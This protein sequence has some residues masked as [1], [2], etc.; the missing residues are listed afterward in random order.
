V[1]Y[2]SVVKSLNPLP[3]ETIYVFMD[4]TYLYMKL[5]CNYMS[6]IEKHILTLPSINQCFCLFSLRM[7]TWS[8]T[9]PNEDELLNAHH[10]ISE[11][12]ITFRYTTTL[13]SDGIMSTYI[14]RK[15]TDKYQH[16]FH[17]WSCPHI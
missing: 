11:S 15:H 12:K 1:W 3:P 17:T 13:F 4:V 2:Q 14:Y 5:I 10:T 6:N 16:L 9:N 7:P 8:G